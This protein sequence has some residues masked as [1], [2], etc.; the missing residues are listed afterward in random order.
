MLFP[1]ISFS[2]IVHYFL[3]GIWWP[4]FRQPAWVSAHSFP[5]SPHPW[6]KCGGHHSWPWRSWYE[7]AS[8]FRRLLL[9][10]RWAGV[11][12]CPVGLV[13]SGES[14]G[15]MQPPSISLPELSW[16]DTEQETEALSILSDDPS[17]AQKNI[18]NLHMCTCTG[19]K[20]V[21]FVEENHLPKVNNV[22]PFRAW[23]VKT[24]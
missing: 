19:R 2:W 18:Q 13:A 11:A 12:D 8:V 20:T 21:V 1:L 24:N 10:D 17:G 23:L 4:S 6:V 3:Q 16:G 7:F 15:C 14:F 5:G 9:D 22:N